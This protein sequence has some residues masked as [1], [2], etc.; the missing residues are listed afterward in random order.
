MK[1]L[2]DWPIRVV[3]A[4]DHLFVRQGVKDLL[5]ECEGMA[6]VGMAADGQQLLRMA[7]TEQPDVVLTD[8]RMP[9]ISGLEAAIIMRQQLPHISLI[10][11]SGDDNPYLILR[12]LEV[13][14][15]GILLKTADRDETMMAVQQVSRGQQYYCR[16]TFAVLQKLAKAGHYDL[17][18]RKVIFTLSDREKTVLKL[19]YRGLT[20]R[21]IGELM[22]RSIRTIEDCRRKLFLKTDTTSLAGLILWAE[23]YKVMEEL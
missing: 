10:A 2:A 22:D 7:E 5:D 17:H 3:V 18:K 1:T 9:G 8:V 19:I 11:L 13:G 4:D 12:M 20:N 21:E 16:G 6:V 14:F 23:R 15:H